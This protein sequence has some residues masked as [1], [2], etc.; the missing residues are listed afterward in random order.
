MFFIDTSRNGQPVYDP[1]VNQ[2]L[3]NYLVNDLKLPGHGLIMYVNQPAV[4]IGINQNA[5]AEVNMPY[6]RKNKIKLVR[7]TSGGGAVYHDFGNII[8]ENIVINDDRHFGDFRYFAQPIIDVLHEMGAKDAQMR[9]RNDMVIGNSKFSGMTMFKVG[10]SYAAGGTLM[11]D[12]NMDVA[13]KVLTPEKDKLASKG[14]KSVHS[15]VTNIKPYLD[16]QYQTMDIEAFKKEL[17]LKLFKVNSLDDIKTYHLNDHDWAIIDQRL[18]GKYDTDEWN[19]GQ[20]PGFD[21]Y[22][23]KHYDIGTVSFNYSLTDQN[24]ISDIK[25]YGDFI[26]GGNIGV[27]EKALQGTELTKPALVNALQSVNL[28]DNLGKV[29]PAAL[30]DLLLEKTPTD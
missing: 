7:R 2:S 4:I 14:V 22:V 20:N 23:S 5:Y 26:T 25:I 12:L 10:Q 6:L 16:S 3:D 9:G 8:F 28:A 27:I 21:Y 1:I 15:R 13:T 30:A 11:F 19:Y 17:L 29:D 24:R 18:Q